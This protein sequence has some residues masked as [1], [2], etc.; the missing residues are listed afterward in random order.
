MIF[1]SLATT[2]EPHVLDVRLLPGSLYSFFLANLSTTG[3]IDAFYELIAS[4]DCPWWVCLFLG[5]CFPNFP[6]WISKETKG[7][8][9]KPKETKENH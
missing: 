5:F 8:Q 3:M 6:A 2:A 9:R 1:A 7:N 4:L